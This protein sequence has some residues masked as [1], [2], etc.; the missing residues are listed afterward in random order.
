MRVPGMRTKESGVLK[1]LAL[2]NPWKVHPTPRLYR[3]YAK[4]GYQENPILHKAIK[5]KMKA[6]CNTPI[7]LFKSMGNDKME[8][9]QNHPLIDVMERPNPA[10]PYRLF[11]QTL[12]LYHSLR[13]EAFMEISQAGKSLELTPIRPDLFKIHK[14]NGLVPEGYELNISA[15]ERVQFPVD[16]ITGLSDIVHI[17]DAN[18]FDMFRGSSEVGAASRSIDIHNEQSDWNI[19]MLQNGGRPSGAIKAVTDEAKGLNGELDPN[20]REQLRKMADEH[21]GAFNAGRVVLL[22]GGLEWQ[23]MGMN[24]KEMDFTKSRAL[25]ANEICSTVGV[26]SQL[27]GIPGSQTFANYEQARLS[28]YVDTVIPLVNYILDYFNFHI[29]PR[30]DPT[31]TLFFGIKKDE[32]DALAP[33]RRELYASLTNSNFLTINEKR[34]MAGLPEYEESENPGDQILVNTGLIPA[35][36]LLSDASP[37]ADPNDVPPF[38]GDDEDDDGES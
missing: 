9:V 24:S 22:E 11:M 26:P 34:R 7:H 8:E 33:L 13:G 32:I 27:L 37:P 35:E 3:A 16:E 36:E 10:M 12:V 25:I 1:Y 5:E 30:L 28:F 38:G 15:N 21:S 19:A 2:L 20:Q 6:V 31:G 17:R 29:V 4:E 23:E 14:G 18:P